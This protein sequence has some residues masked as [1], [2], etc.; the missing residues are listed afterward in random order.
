MLFLALGFQYNFPV[1]S[2]TRAQRSA[3]RL[4]KIANAV[5]LIGVMCN[6]STTS[7]LIL[8]SPLT[9]LRCS[10][11]EARVSDHFILPHPMFFPDIRPTSDSP[12]LTEASKAGSSLVV[13]TTDRKVTSSRPGTPGGSDDTRMSG[14]C[15][16]SYLAWSGSAICVAGLPFASS[17]LFPSLLDSR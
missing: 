6:S 15:G 7:I 11:S 13:N 16:K 10:P 3:T 17:Y 5:T 4:R 8:W 14:E 1:V 12:Q 9:Q 2:S